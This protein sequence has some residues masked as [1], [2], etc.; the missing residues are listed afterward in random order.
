[1]SDEDRPQNRDG[2]IERLFGLATWVVV[3]IGVAV[4]IGLV[5]FFVA[6]GSGEDL[7]IDL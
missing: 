5:I 4:V 6:L 1:M 3:L 2:P 7:P